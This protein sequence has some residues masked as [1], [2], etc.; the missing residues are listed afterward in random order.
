MTVKDLQQRDVTANG[1]RIHFAEQGTG[2]LVLLCHGFPEGWYSWR[3]QL[4]GA[5]RRRI[6]RGRARHARLWTHRRTGRHLFV[7]HP[8]YRRRHDR[9]GRRARREAGHHRRA[10]LGRQHRV[11][12]GVVSSGC[13]P[14]RCRSQRSLSPARSGAAAAHAAQGRSTH[15]LLVSLSRTRRGRG[16]IRA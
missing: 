14:R 16:R 2:P 9:P 8:R 15:P 12:C 4:R 13:V 10:R 6:S 3:D 1:I 11:A 7:H 5:R